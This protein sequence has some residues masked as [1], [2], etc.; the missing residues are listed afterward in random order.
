MFPENKKYTATRCLIQ[1]RSVC[2]SSVARISH[3]SDTATDQLHVLVPIVI[4]GPRVQAHVQ[5]LHSCA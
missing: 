4:F 3:V 2:I 1:L 5:P